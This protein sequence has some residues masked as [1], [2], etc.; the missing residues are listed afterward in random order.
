MR[1]I[2]SEEL[3][4]IQLDILDKIHIFCEQKNINYSLAFGT[5]LGAVRH[6]GYIPWD[7]DID[8]MIPRPDYLRFVNSFNG[9]Y[10]HLVVA[11]PELDWNYYAPYA[12]VYDS[13]TLLYEGA[14]SHR[15][16]ELGVKIDVFPI[17]GTPDSM[18]NYLRLRK[19]IWNLNGLLYAKRYNLKMSEIKIPIF[20]G[21]IKS[22]FLSYT[23]IQKMIAELLLSNSYSTSIFVDELAFNPYMKSITRVPISLFSNYI[24]LPFENRYFRAIADYDTFLKNVYGN[25]MELPPKEKQIP[26]HG[27]TAYWR[28]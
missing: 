17:D 10:P 26:H 19:K 7:D 8:I 24:E 4:A 15:G 20:K 23:K 18:E 21:K 6:K 5:L 9:S 12:N 3:N 1:V 16:L 14:N 28:N 22:I 2:S 11:A 27:F 25:Y 13:R